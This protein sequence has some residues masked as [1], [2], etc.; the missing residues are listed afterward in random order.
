MHLAS[1]LCPVSWALGW[2]DRPIIVGVLGVGLLIAVGLEIGRRR[3]GPVR[4]RSL[5]RRGVT[6]LRDAEGRRVE[7]EV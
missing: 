4:R 5:L 6:Q 7:A 2:V 1:T 3:A